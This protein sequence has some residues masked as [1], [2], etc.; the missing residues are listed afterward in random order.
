M[1]D[2]RKD[3]EEASVAGAEQE[4]GTMGAE[5]REEGRPEP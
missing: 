3:G 2:M 5:V 4:K 1:P